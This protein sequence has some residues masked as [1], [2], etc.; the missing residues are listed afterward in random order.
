MKTI[1][2]LVNYFTLGLKTISTSRIFLTTTSIISLVLI[3][4]VVYRAI[5]LKNKVDD[6][7]NSIIEKLETTVEIDYPKHDS[8]SQ[9]GALYLTK[10]LKA[11]L[12]EEELSPKLLNIRKVLENKFNE[13]NYNFAF[14]Y[15]EL[16]TGFTLSY[17]SSQP[18]FAASAIKAPEAI[19]I[20][21][22]AENLLHIEKAVFSCGS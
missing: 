5:S 16:Y 9:T 18:I 21:K 20:Y 17:N 22:Q 8:P 15:K 11:P 7:E 6:L 2:K 12:T 13:S 14:K 3:S 10:C 19:Y 4:I 1:K